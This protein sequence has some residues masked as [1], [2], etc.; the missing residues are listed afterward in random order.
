M[1]DERAFIARIEGMQPDEF[2]RLLA[3]PTPEEESALRLHLG[4]ERYE[5]LH[6]LA[7]RRATRGREARRGNVVVIHGIMGGELTSYDRKGGGDRVWVHVLRLLTGSFGRLRLGA[8]GVSE[9]DP[10]YD[11]RATGILKNAYGEQLLH[12]SGDW[13][14]RAFWFDWRKDLRLAAE[15]LYAQLSA[16]FGDAPVHLVAHS[17]GGLVARTFIHHFPERWARMWDEEGGGRSGGRLIMLGTPNHGSY[18]VPQILTG[19]EPMVKKLARVDLRHNLREVT[20]IATSFL[21]SYQMLPSPYVAEGAD[22]LYR[23][24]SYGAGRGVPQHHLDRARA[25]HEQLRHVVDPKRMV[26]VAGFNRTTLC[27]VRPG[28]PLDSADAYLTTREGDGRVPHLLGRLEGVKTYYVEED[29]G[30]LPGNRKVL[31]AMGELLEHGETDRLPREM[32]ALRALAA[33]ADEHARHAA[34]EARRAADE[35]RLDLALERLRARGTADA[36]LLAEEERVVERLVLREWVGGGVGVD[37]DEGAGEPASPAPAEEAAR[38]PPLTLALALGGID[39]ADLLAA[40]PIDALAVGLYVGVRPEGAGRALDV[41]LSRALAGSTPETEAPD[42]AALLTPLA[43]RGALRGELGRLSLLPD[44]RLPGRVVALAGMG[45]PG[46]CGAP[47]LALLTRELCWTLGRLGKKHLAAVLI[48]SGAGNLAARDAVAAWIAGLRA[49]RQGA[50]GTARLE[51][52]TLV[53]LDPA[54]IAEIDAALCAETARAGA[55]FAYVP[56]SPEALD[57]LEPAIR[58]QEAR[59]RAAAGER[60]PDDRPPT[61]LTLSLERREGRAAFRFG[62]I[63]ESASIPEREIP[64][65][66]SLVEEANDEL[67]ALDDLARQLRRGRYLERLLVPRDLRGELA[68]AAPLVLLLDAATARI[69]WEMVAQPGL[70]GEESGASPAEP[71]ALFLGTAR[72]LTRQLRTPFA[73]LPDP[74]PRPGRALRALI[75]A[76]PAADARLPGAEEEGYAVADLFERANALHA[77]AGGR[78]VEVVRLFGPRR[79]TRTQVLEALMEEPFDLLHFAGHCIYA[80]EDPAAS[81]WIFTG[82]KRLSAHELRRVDRVPRFVFSNACES[83]LT[84]DRSERRTAA[85]APSFAEA[86]FERGVSDFVC[87]AWPVGDGAARTFALTLYAAL[88]GLGACGHIDALAA[89]P[90]EP[91]H[92]AMREAR[93]ALA[94][95][96]AARRYWGAYQHYGNPYARLIA[97]GAPWR[98]GVGAAEAAVAAGG[99]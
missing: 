93:L 69:H 98:E 19:L 10:R 73:P 58:E 83:G 24:E 68:S 48:G 44:P 2:A 80:P 52:I 27:G 29:H 92:V 20:E 7:L 43:E 57:A 18:A 63:T 81:G 59:R 86:F 56:W 37:A 70:L 13:E 46:R 94:H 64:L 49:A 15:Q 51:R 61:R 84:P 62:A 53:E 79:A 23:A 50:E 75:V 3:A 96:P 35:A 66:P 36:P 16:W 25:F 28:A 89:R 4:E 65:D 30:D 87:T 32:P 6:E 31:Q 26:Y 17:M 45:Y 11:V 85:L 12:L 77:P 40:E 78:A 9:H 76:D 95:T 71:D 1:F 47:E 38:T 8:D 60:A 21:G 22:V 14:V 33:E 97:A 99:V 88:L 34:D 67:P 74:L 39:E 5:R 72:A 55:E 41:A 82:G 91:M 90:P 42:R 54:R